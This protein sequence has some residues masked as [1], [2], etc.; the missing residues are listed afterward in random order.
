MF[1]YL[2]VMRDLRLSERCLW[3]EV[4]L[5]GRDGGFWC[6]QGRKRLHL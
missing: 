6:F 5:C 2:D 3:C 1:R 4:T